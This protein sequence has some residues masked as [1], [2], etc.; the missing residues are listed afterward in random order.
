MAKLTDIMTDV[1]K[2][3]GGVWFP[4]DAGIELLIASTKTP[5]FRKARAKLLKPFERR[6]R[7]KS[8]SSE[9][10]INALKPAY[11]KHVLVGWRN[12]EDDKSKPLVYSYE[13]A[14]EF[15]NNPALS[16]FFDFVLECADDDSRFRVESIEDAEKN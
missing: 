8:M 9:E 15:F 5:E 14:L 6:I 2:A 10:V 3:E 16:A 12:L 1:K 13:K 4:Y 11:A 7:S